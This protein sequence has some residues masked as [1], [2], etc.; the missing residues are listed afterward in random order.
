MFGKS[1]QD[2]FKVSNI[3]IFLVFQHVGITIDVTPEDQQ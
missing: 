3:I 2:V 1:F